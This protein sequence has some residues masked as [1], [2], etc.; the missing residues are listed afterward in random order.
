MQ[1]DAHLSPILAEVE[2]FIRFQ[3]ITEGE[4]VRR[5][6]ERADTKFIVIEH[7]G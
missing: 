5:E 3:D 7:K 1:W 6:S 4:T 2:G